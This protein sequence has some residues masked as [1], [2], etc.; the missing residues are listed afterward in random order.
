MTVIGRDREVKLLTES[1]ATSRPELIAIHGRRRVG[2]TFLVREIYSKNVIFDI[3]GLHKGS[4]KDQLSNFYNQIVFRDK[5]FA[6]RSVPK[7][8]MSS[9]ALLQEYIDRNSSKKKKV[10]FID[11]FP[12]INKNQVVDDAIKM[13]RFHSLRYL[14]TDENLRGRV[15]KYFDASGIVKKIIDSGHA[16]DVVYD[17]PSGFE[18]LAKLIKPGLTR[19]CEIAHHSSSRDLKYQELY[20]N[21]KTH[22]PVRLFNVCA[23]NPVNLCDLVILNRIQ[24]NIS[25]GL[26]ADFVP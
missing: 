11:E 9:F 14:L 26:V 19:M 20:C 22:S 8:W 2:K 5:G 1:L 4:L 3:T 12:Y 18:K 24:N 15:G 16:E 10:I 25:L 6:V 13:G 21:T 23:N 7:D 17:D